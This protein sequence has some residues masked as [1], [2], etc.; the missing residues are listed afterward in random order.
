MAEEGRAV[1]QLDLIPPH[2]REPWA[3]GRDPEMRATELHRVRTQH[4][5]PTEMLG[6]S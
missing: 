4:S 1:K 3:P 6:D 5:A 2:A